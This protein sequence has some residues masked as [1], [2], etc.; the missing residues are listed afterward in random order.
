M[1]LSDKDLD[2][3]YEWILNTMKTDTWYP[4]KSDKAFEIIFKL[5]K[6]GLIDFC[7]FDQNQTHFRKIDKN[8]LDND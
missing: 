2:K 7:E 8:F 3:M 1:E 4:V 6:E 5:F